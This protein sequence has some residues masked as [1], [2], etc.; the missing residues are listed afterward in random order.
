MKGKPRTVFDPRPPGVPGGRGYA[1]KAKN[2]DL[3]EVTLGYELAHTRGH[4]AGRARS[5]TNPLCELHGMHV[6][7]WDS[8]RA[9]AHEA[10]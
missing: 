5:G 1:N 6:A 7:G 10:D 9:G 2:F 8:T 3:K 4:V